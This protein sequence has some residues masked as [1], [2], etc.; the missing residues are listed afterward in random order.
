MWSF[1]GGI[2]NDKSITATKES[3]K[4]NT[5]TATAHRKRK[6]LNEGESLYTPPDK[7]ESIASTRST[8]EPPRTTLATQSASLIP[9]ADDDLVAI[10]AAEQ[11]AMFEDA[12]AL[13]SLID[14]QLKAKMTRF[15]S[16][17]DDKFEDCEDTSSGAEEDKA[18]EQ[19]NGKQQRELKKLRTQTSKKSRDPKFLPP[20]DPYYDNTS[21]NRTSRYKPS[22]KA[23]ENTYG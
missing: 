2:Y 5:C 4:S 15:K 11:A 21:K 17:R 22:K 8:F 23:L 3:S 9:S 13:Q 1:S 16:T 14:E 12:S 10:E 7:I 20:E 18:F 19:L 6:I